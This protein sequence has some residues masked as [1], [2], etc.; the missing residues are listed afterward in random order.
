MMLQL[1]NEVE[2]EALPAD[3]PESIH[4]DITELA[5][6]G[7]QILI[8]SI[9]APTGVTI[10]SEPSQA[11]FRIEELVS[12]EALEQE[13]QEEAEAAEASQESAEATADTQS[14]EESSEEAPKE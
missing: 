8:E 1:V 14:P 5:E 2:I 3:L 4:V 11:V 13:A 7:D 6:V 10:L 9:N 12:E